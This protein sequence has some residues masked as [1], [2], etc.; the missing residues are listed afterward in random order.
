MISLSD[1]RGKLGLTDQ[2]IS[3]SNIF[4]HT[5]ELK[6]SEVRDTIANLHMYLRTQTGSTWVDITDSNQNATYMGT[7]TT[8]TKFGGGYTTPANQTTR[9]ILLP[10]GILQSL[11]DGFNWTLS[12]WLEILSVSGTRHICSM[13]DTTTDNAFIV[14]YTSSAMYISNSVL[15]GGQHLSYTLNTPMMLTVTRSGPQNFSLWKNGVLQGYYSTP[16]NNTK[17]VQGWVL[18]QEQDTIKGAFQSTQNTNGN[19]YEVMLYNTLLTPTQILSEY[20]RTK[21]RFIV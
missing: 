6:L 2:P 19:W 9:Y 21:G 15:T 20:N 18:D 10:E 16:S 7:L 13:A 1:V 12:I 3:F 5:S 14:L 17:D 11:P 8:T 4:N